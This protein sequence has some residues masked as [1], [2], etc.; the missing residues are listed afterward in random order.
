MSTK[1]EDLEIKAGDGVAHKLALFEVEPSAEDE[2]IAVP[3]C[4][5][6]PPPPGWFTSFEQAGQ[7]LSDELSNVFDPGTHDDSGESGAPLKRRRLG[8]VEPV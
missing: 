7:V 3:A 6:V 1:S 4:L 8:P 5:D 2:Y